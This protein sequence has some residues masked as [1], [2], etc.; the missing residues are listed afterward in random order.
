MTAG[1]D[2]HAQVLLTKAAEDEAVLFVDGIPDGPFGFH[3]QQAIEKLL[4]AL[5]SQLSKEYK[6]THDLD[7]LELQLK[8]AGEALPKGLEDFSKIGTFAVTNRYDDIPEFHVLD[9]QAAIAT[10]RLIREH[11]V[12]RIAA[13]S[14][15]P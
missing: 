12:A 7:H 11:V 14:S 8:D 4:K 10:V 6:F 2:R 15:A 3:V 1:I 5:L 13:L 9:R